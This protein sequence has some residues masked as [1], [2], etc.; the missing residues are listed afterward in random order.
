MFT[1][2]G[3]V[4]AFKHDRRR[5]SKGVDLSLSRLVSWMSFVLLSTIVACQAS[6]SV[7]AMITYGEGTAQ[8]PRWRT[9]DGISWSSEGIALSI[10]GEIL[11]S[12]LR[13]CPRR[14]EQI[15]GVLDSN[16]HL[17]MQVR[18]DS[19]WGN[20]IE[21]TTAIGPANSVYRGFD[22]EYEQTSGRAIVVYH[23]NTYD[24]VYRIWDGSSWTAAQTIDLPTVGVP[25]WIELASDPYANS[26]ALITLDDQEDVGGAI[27]NGSGW[28]DLDRLT[29]NAF[30]YQEKGVDVSFYG[31]S[32]EALFVYGPSNRDGFRFRVHDSGGWG[33]AGDG[34]DVGNKVR[35]VRLAPSMSTDS[36]SVAWVADDS[37]GWAAIWDGIGIQQTYNF[38]PDSV[39]NKSAQ[40]FDVAWE[41][42]G[43]QL[44]VA[45]S[46]AS[47][48]IGQASYCT[49]RTGLWSSTMPGPDMGDT[50]QLISLNS[51]PGHDR[52]FL[53]T[54]ADD[55]H[56]SVAQWNG[57]DW[58]TTYDLESNI[59]TVMNGPLSLSFTLGPV[60]APLLQSPADGSWTADSRPTFQWVAPNHPD[61]SSY[62]IFIDSDSAFTP[63]LEV[64]DSTQSTDYTP[65]VDLVDGQHFW[66]VT[67]VDSMNN[68]GDTSEIWMIG[69]DTQPPLKPESLTADGSS[70]SPWKNSS[71]FSIDMN[72]PVDPSG[73]AYHFFKLGTRPINPDDTSGS[74]ESKPFNVDAVTEGGES[75]FVWLSD[76]VGNVD[77]G[78]WEYVLLRYDNQPPS[79]SQA[80]S[81]PFSNSTRFQV[82]WTTGSDAGGSGLTGRYD[83]KVKDEAGPW[84]YW[85]Q[86]F[87]A[88]SDTFDGVA[89]HI[90]YF[91]A[92]SMD[93]AGNVELFLGVPECSTFIDTVRPYLISTIPANGDTGVPVGTDII[94]VFSEQMNTATL[95]TSNITVYGDISGYHTFLQNYSN[96]T[97][98]LSPWFQFSPGE[99][100][101]VSIKKEVEDL[102]G[103]T[104]SSD[105]I[106]TFRLEIPP[107]T[108]GPMIDS[109]SIDPE[110]P[111]QGT[112]NL[113]VTAVVS[114]STT[115]MS[116]ITAAQLVIDSTGGIP[117]S[118]NPR[119][120]VF[121]HF[122]EW[123]VDTINISGWQ[124]GETH[125][126]YVRGEDSCGNWG[127]FDS[128]P[129][130]VISPDDSIPPTVAV[131][132]PDSGEID[133]PTNT[134]IYIT[135]SERVEDSTV[136]K[137][138]FVVHGIVGYDFSYAQPNDS[139]VALYPFALFSPLESV[140]VFI[141]R[142]IKDLGGNP[143][144][145]D[146]IFWFRTAESPDTNDPSVT[147]VTAYPETV[148]SDTA[149]TLMATIKDD[150]A[151]SDAECFI[152]SIGTDGDGLH[153]T[154]VDSFGTDSVDVIDT[155]SITTLPYGTRWFYVHGKDKVGNWGTFDSA[156]VHIP[157]PDTSGPSFDIIVNPH[158]IVLGESVWVQV[159]PSE[160]LAAVPACLLWDASDNSVPLA[161]SQSDSIYSTA[162]FPVGLSTGLGR[163]EV[164]G[165]DLSGNPGSSDT[166]CSIVPGWD[167]LP[168]KSVY[169]YPNPAPTAYYGNR[170]HFRFYVGSNADVTVDIYTIEGKFVQRMKGTG[171]GGSK[172]N[173]IIWS[174]DR[175]ASQLLFYRVVATSRE[176]GQ[177][178]AVIKKL[179][180]TK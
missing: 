60:P 108:L 121:D 80:Q 27:W 157:Q 171:Q 34:P 7:P 78:N 49:W 172:E 4:F 122:T 5:Y 24:P 15:L 136:T 118:M 31:K 154:A 89:G 179:A 82:S 92:A 110:S 66:R 141:D 79:G 178:Q 138:K 73:I 32:G 109:L 104:M 151:V 76:S 134:D 81:P 62:R 166:L 8:E 100:A 52:I 130:Y 99:L 98:T 16:G 55:R 45:W 36:L 97:L 12:E 47:D 17:N 180:I 91:E 124:A 85:L 175:I 51:S 72:Y 84:S 6:A 41:H 115:G 61:V 29:N 69:I 165:I 90:Y 159:I 168:K 128:I 135:F 162:F 105:Y 133:V 11:W 42:S 59:S 111:K 152:D 54:V 142:S 70:P 95:D 64:L 102:A 107:D 143:M 177:S 30:S 173:E 18:T 101:T 114:D 93:S 75:L 103:N 14:N 126:I 176:T 156:W 88:L 28:T 68:A 35:Q 19:I 58:G 13:S 48:S 43:D 74:S 57:N 150:R 40:C 46:E 164:S 10:G 139:T 9:W 96:D 1:V 86:D 155:I 119:D 120:A 3:T 113:I 137:D 131:T 149:I 50:I 39:T 145:D 83:I 170:V 94:I 21:L 174:I 140:T 67:A 38:E 160:V 44:L 127:E 123:V 146:Y 148:Y 106:F 129:V 163:V 25:V 153:L 2:Q 167:F 20:L 117:Y 125:R 144:Q 63:P 56:L 161:L 23:E 169:A 147:C 37:K 77:Y 53:Q 132:V 116:T 65:T 26:V 158:P 112:G 22:I 33:S 87:G 71:S